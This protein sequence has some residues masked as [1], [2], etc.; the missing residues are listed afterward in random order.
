MITSILQKMSL[1]HPYSFQN[2]QMFYKEATHRQSRNE[3]LNMYV[4]A[5]LLL[6]GSPDLNFGRNTS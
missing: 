3:A 1:D 5:A 6:E 2:V 4:L